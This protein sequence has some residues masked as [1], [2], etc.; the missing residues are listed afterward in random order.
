MLRATRARRTRTTLTAAWLLS[1]GLFAQAESL[2]AAP[3][4]IRILWTSVEQSPACP[5]DAATVEDEV[6]RIFRDIGVEIDWSVP[7]GAVE[8][9]A[10]DLR[11]IAVF[12]DA[13]RRP[14]V[15]GST[16]R[17]SREA[18]VY[19][20]PIARSLGVNPAATAATVLPL[21]RAV[22]RVAAH[23]VVHMLAPW[24]PHTEQ[25]LMAAHWD[26]AELKG[27][28]L[29]VDSQTRF[30]VLERLVPTA[31]GPASVAEPIDR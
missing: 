19:C 22:A 5:L 23:E 11:V 16:T 3:P 10:G 25:G 7:R 29:V 2:E 14:R 8:T 26:R 28:R 15:L 9:S 24:H 4:R 12:S 20:S 30:A 13:A 1:S 31:A 21:S 6:R 18:W 27:P 17:G